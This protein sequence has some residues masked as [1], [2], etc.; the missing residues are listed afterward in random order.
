MCG[1]LGLDIFLAAGL[2]LDLGDFKIDF[3]A[4]IAFMLLLARTVPFP[5]GPFLFTKGV[6]KTVFFLEFTVK[7]VLRLGPNGFHCVL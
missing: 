2:L 7:A 1:W 3:M 6:S 4:F 5:K